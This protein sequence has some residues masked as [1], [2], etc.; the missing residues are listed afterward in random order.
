[1]NS[2]ELGLCHLF[3]A[4][5]GYRGP[6]L[7]PLCSPHRVCKVGLQTLQLLWPRVW[8]CWKPIFEGPLISL[9]QSLTVT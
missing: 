6:V 4:V 7:A 5:Y 3:E 9:T 8:A 1:M 2:E